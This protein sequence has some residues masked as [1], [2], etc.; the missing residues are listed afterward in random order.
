MEANIHMMKVNSTK[1]LKDEMRRIGADEVGINLMLPKGELLLIKVQNVSLKAANIL[2]QEMLSRG[3]EAVLHKEV[4]MLTK[5]F[6]DVLLMGTKKQFLEVLGKLNLQPFGLKKTAEEIKNVIASKE[7][8]KKARELD[9]KGIFLPMNKRTL[10]MGILNVTPDSFSDGGKYNNIDEAIVHAKQ[11]VEAGAD[12]IDIGGESTRP[13]HHSVSLEEELERVIPVIERLSKEI[14]IPIS[15]DTYKSKVAKRAII[16]GAHM[17]NDVWGFKKDPDMAKVA[18][19]FHVPSILMHNREKANYNSLLDDIIFDLKESINIALSAGVKKEN[20]ILDPGIGF[21]KS[22]ED[23]LLVMNRL[24]EI[25]A[26]GYPV[27]LGTSRKSMIGLTLDLPVN[28][29]MEGTA[30]TITL[31]IMKGCKIIR[32]HDVKEMKRVAEMTDAMVC[33]IANRR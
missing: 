30:A 24:D 4:S 11:M 20:I 19:E 21:A 16:A 2:K 1:Q 5:E 17:I 10:I 18:A 32:V 9:C 6:S 28:E 33:P 25:V 15:I 3:G 14:S 7:E 27:L 8:I 12:V 26:L 31:G 22:Y 23:N 29:R 13:G